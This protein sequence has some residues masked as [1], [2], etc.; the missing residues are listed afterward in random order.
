MTEAI[1]N[2]NR[3]YR[4]LFVFQKAR[5]LA[6]ETIRMTEAFPKSETY[7]TVSQMRRA[8]LSV[9][10]NIAEGNCR[11]SRNEHIKFLRIAYASSGELGSQL[12]VSC[13][14]HWMDKASFDHMETLIDNVSGLL[15]RLMESLKRPQQAPMPQRGRLRQ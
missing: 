7:G 11:L 13:D 1:S 9:V 10:S 14:V 8:S 4:D 15:W 6:S 2:R 12:L 3:G 5:G